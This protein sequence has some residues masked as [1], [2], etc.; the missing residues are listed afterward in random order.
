MQLAQ[1]TQHKE[2]E[3]RNS[4]SCHICLKKQAE[5]NAACTVN[6]AEGVRAEELEK[7]P[8]SLR[9]IDKAKENDKLKHVETSTTKHV[10]IH[11]QLLQK[12]KYL[13]S[14]ESKAKISHGMLFLYPCSCLRDK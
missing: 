7:M 4:R 1:L 11:P 9:R 3:M 8:H 14:S 2:S 13:I 6:S 5:K 12:Q 10:L